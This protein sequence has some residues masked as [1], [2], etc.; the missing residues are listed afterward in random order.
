MP[1]TCRKCQVSGSD[2]LTSVQ[3]TG[4]SLEQG[5][6]KLS[7]VEGKGRKCEEMTSCTDSLP[8]QDLYIKLMLTCC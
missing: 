8:V 1:Q 7:K 5:E 6:L 3:E 4:G 2:R